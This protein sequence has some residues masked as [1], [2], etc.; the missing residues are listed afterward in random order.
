MQKKKIN[1]TAPIII[2]GYG[3][4]SDNERRWCNTVLVL[5]DTQI[6]LE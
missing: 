2:V 4:D 5:M 1:A 6:E 3:F